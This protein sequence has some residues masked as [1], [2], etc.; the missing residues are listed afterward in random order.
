MAVT[1]LL[2]VGQKDYEKLTALLAS[3]QSEIAELLDE[4]LG[5]A[6]VVP[7]ESLPSDVVSM[8]AKV[9]FVDLD[10]GK[11]THV[12]LVYPEDANVEESK[13]SILAPIGAALIGLKVGQSIDWPLPSGKTRHIKVV[14]VEHSPS[15]E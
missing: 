5:R 7:D 14:K 8:N 13:I 15:E 12:T 9:T 2:T 11:E 1:E 6:K 4:E 10:S 3:A